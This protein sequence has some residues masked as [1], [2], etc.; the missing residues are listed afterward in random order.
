MKGTSTREFIEGKVYS[1]GGTDPY[2]FWDWILLGVSRLG[3]AVI[4]SG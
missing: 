1:Q 2:L 4:D 3:G